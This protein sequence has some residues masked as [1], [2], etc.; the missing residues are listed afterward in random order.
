MTR[1]SLNLIC[2]FL[3]LLSLPV[4]SADVPEW[5]AA[6]M[7]AYSLEPGQNL[8]FVRGPID[9]RQAY[10][11]NKENN[12]QPM[13]YI[14]WRWKNQKLIR[15]MMRASGPTG[16]SLSAVVQDCAGLDPQ[17]IELV[18]LAGTNADGDWIV[19]DCATP[20]QILA[21]LRTIVSDQFGVDLQI[22]KQEV[23]KEAIVVTGKYK[24]TRLPDSGSREL[25][26]FSDVLDHPGPG[27]SIQGGGATTLAEFWKILGGDIGMPIV[28]EAQGEPKKLNWLLSRSV[29]RGQSEAGRK[30]ILQNLT[31]QTG[32][33]FTPAK[34]TFTH[35]KI[36]GIQSE[37]APDQKK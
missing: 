23:E 14:Q 32:L 15:Q 17:Q 34:R 3:A 9:E 33:S 29:T 22:S 1:Q 36:T 26:V 2:V 7:K 31:A 27:D 28:D 21:D 20:E 11:A 5:E 25:Q 37:A 6:L 12:P 16:A 18:G 8:R 30:Q 4:A 10:L 19:R 35:W 24:F 13:P